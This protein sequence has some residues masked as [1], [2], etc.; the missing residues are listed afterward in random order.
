MEA[1]TT[2]SKVENWFQGFNPSVNAT[3]DTL[4]TLTEARDEKNRNLI[5]PKSF[6]VSTS[7]LPPALLDSL[8]KGDTTMIGGEEFYWT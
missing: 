6:R 2:Q 8:F 7:A 4:G 5:C 1:T 3:I